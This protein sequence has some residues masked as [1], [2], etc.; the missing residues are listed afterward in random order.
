MINQAQ[1]TS[2]ASQP[3]GM[4]Y[5]NGVALSGVHSFEV[6]NNAFFQADT[7]RLTLLI[8]AQPA[9]RGLDFWSRQEQLELEFLL[10]FPADPD[11]V[12][13]SGLGSFLLGYADA[14]DVDLDANTLVL[15]GR[16]F[17]SKLIDVK[18]TKVFSSGTL[19]ASDVVRQI[20]QAQGLTPVVTPTTV[21]AGGYYQI[22]K[23]LVASDVS[24]W[25]IVTKLAQYEGYQVY[26]RGRELHFEPRAAKGADPYVLRWQ[27]DGGAAWSNA[28]QLSFKRDLSLAKDLRVKVLS[29]HSKTN[30]A[31]S[32]VAERKRVTDG[33]AV[34]FGGEPQ[35]YV[36]TFPN[37]DASQ[38]QAKA[39]AI[40][41]ELSAHEMGLT[42]E[43]PGD[44]L[45][46][47]T[48]LIQV[49]GTGSAFDQTYYAASVTR[50]YSSEDGFRMTVHAK[51]QTPN[52]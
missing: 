28:M 13:K 43:L 22:V 46:M 18:R 31:V 25:D 23:A 52:H 2:A 11:N 42:A 27:A 6:E 21:A 36:R 24:Y 4:V 12:G 9:G 45:L 1:P 16:D 48:S 17:S 7:F 47:P 37:L 34:A 19:V 14:I 50:R 26:V 40:L 20:A 32:E 33:A 39:K 49:T 51:N 38:A 35:E 44:V 15:T 30:Q 10:G 8:S 29:F 5:A 41:Q 3:R